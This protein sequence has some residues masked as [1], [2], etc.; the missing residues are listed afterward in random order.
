MW[1]SCTT[2]TH[3]CAAVGTAAKDASHILH[4]CDHS[5]VASCCTGGLHSNSLS[6]AN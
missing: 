4:T 5:V 6:K 1:S 3:R 2:S